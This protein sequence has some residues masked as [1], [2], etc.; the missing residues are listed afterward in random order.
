MKILF[1]SLGW[2]APRIPEIPPV[3]YFSKFLEGRSLLSVCTRVTKA[4]LSLRTTE[5]QCDS[6]RSRVPQET[7]LYFT[8]H[9]PIFLQI[10]SHK[11]CRRQEFWSLLERERDYRRDRQVESEPSRTQKI[12]QSKFACGEQTVQ[13]T[14]NFWQTESFC[15]YEGADTQKISMPSDALSKRA[16]VR[17]A[18]DART[19]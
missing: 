2:G 9:S 8:T 13:G 11:M 3:P 10:Y 18:V 4:V 17:S 1:L 16:M 12:S 19:L 5:R 14:W 6:P 15:F 7:S